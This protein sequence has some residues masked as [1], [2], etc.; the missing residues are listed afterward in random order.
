MRVISGGLPVRNY[1]GAILDREE[2]PEAREFFDTNRC[3]V[4]LLKGWTEA[5]LKSPQTRIVVFRNLPN[6][7]GEAQAGSYPGRLLRF[8]ADS[9]VAVISYVQGFSADTDIGFKISREPLDAGSHVALRLASSTQN[10]AA[11]MP[12][13]GIQR[14]SSPATRALPPM[15]AVS[16]NFESG[17]VKF[18]D[19]DKDQELIYD[20]TPLVASSP[21]VLHGFLNDTAEGKA[22]LVSIPPLNLAIK[23]PSIEPVSVEFSDAANST[24]LAISVELRDFERPPSFV[25]LR[26]SKL[27]A[28]ERQD[29]ASLKEPFAPIPGGIRQTPMSI[30]DGR[31]LIRFD[32]TAPRQDGEE[33]TYLL[34]FAWN[35][36]EGEQTPSRSSRPFVVTLTRKLGGV[37]AATQGIKNLSEGAAEA[38][39]AG[40][41]FPLESPVIA[42]FE[43]SGGR[44]ILM[45]LQGEPFWKRFS[46]EKKQWLPLPDVNLSTVDL[47]GNLSSLFVLDRGAAEVRRY[48]LTDLALQATGKVALTGEQLFAIRAGCNS[49]RAP[50]HVLCSGGPVSLDSATLE[51]KDFPSYREGMQQQTAV[52]CRATGDGITL[53]RGSGF[54]DSLSYAGDIRGLVGGYFDNSENARDSGAMVSRAFM[55]SGRE[56]A[57]CA[58]PG[59]VLTKFADSPFQDSGN[60]YSTVPNGLFVVHYQP[61]ERRQ[62]PPTAPR[63]E[64]M[65]FLNGEI[66]AA[67]QAPEL[68][69]IFGDRAE[70]RN[71]KHHICFDPHSRR[72]GILTGD[73]KTWTVRDAQFN[74]SRK[75]P[76]LMNW[77]DTSIA[78][79][80]EFRFAPQTLGEGQ[81]S[82]EL[83]GAKEPT[84]AKVENNVVSFRV[85]PNELASLLLLK[86]TL[87]GPQGKMTIPVPIHVQG[88]PVAFV[89]P[90]L[91]PGTSP[92]SFAAGFKSL[93]TPKDKRR[94]LNS[95]FYR[96]SERIREIIGVVNGHLAFVTSAKQV[97]FLS[98]TSKT[99]GGSI[100]APETARFYPGCGALYEYDTN[101]RALTRVSVPEG[102]RGPAFTL[103]A[104]F[105]L[106]AI[107]AGSERNEPLS[108]LVERRNN[109]QSSKFGNYTVTTWDT[110]RA[111]IAVNGETLQAGAWMQP[112]LWTDKSNPTAGNAALQLFGGMNGFPARIQGSRNGSILALPNHYAIIS[113]RFSAIT[114]YDAARPVFG[115]GLERGAVLGSMTGI[116]VSTSDGRIVRSGVPEALR[117]AVRDGRSVTTPCGRY[118]MACIEEK[119]SVSYE[120]RTIENNLPLFRLNRIVAWGAD[121]EDQRHG[122]LAKIS[123]LGDNGPLV[124]RSRGGQTLQFLDFDIP[125]LARELLPD[126]FHVTS[127]P[128]PVLI[129]GGTFDYQVQ[130]NNPAL[131]T[132]YRL[133]DP[134]PGAT[135]S[136]TGL[137]R[138]PAPQNVR[139]PSRLTA[140]IEIIGKNG[141]TV[142]HSFPLIVVPRQAGQP[143]PGSPRVF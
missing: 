36:T 25:A 22:D 47:A 12:H 9:G 19:K 58:V 82:A 120:V 128:M 68:A 4:T 53:V 41:S 6:S 89:W 74:E 77:P 138:F 119:G 107:G 114:P 101:T 115:S 14:P 99:V 71:S 39:P 17:T 121:P 110:N 95:A 126:S 85:A 24:T 118:L 134:L 80:D 38:A 20:E 136:S 33:L 16:G 44:E 7:Q 2:V 75:Q 93:E 51:R 40:D 27:S 124:V 100:P 65:N 127:Q 79:G 28:S 137:F 123:M 103:P 130:V 132:G 63:V 21:S 45:Q 109:E 98:V 87:A 60:F 30:V 88:P 10:T 84:P 57:T 43:I 62:I 92:E 11:D 116:V 8:D 15:K 29:V 143:K 55:L 37:V 112:Q 131:V 76:I 61:G 54:F 78:R 81:W 34:Q 122:S 90:D 106:I 102:R 42:V 26:S 52:A 97:N 140:S 139:A 49:D 83:L 23:Q 96:S 111:M 18:S 32:L 69:G 56:F 64:C 1:T 129:E 3:V 135:I 70:D 142:L 46:M 125:T 133:R 113:P 31:G 117:E 13:P 91:N 35:A 108:L 66:F 94:A 48:R 67:T 5:Q 59:G 104:N 73:A 72:F 105:E 141:K 50:V 86:L